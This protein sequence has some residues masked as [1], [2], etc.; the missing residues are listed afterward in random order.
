MSRRVFGKTYVRNF[1]TKLTDNYGSH[2]VRVV[3]L[4]K[5]YEKYFELDEDT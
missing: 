4:K 5:L 2:F 3:D 1:L